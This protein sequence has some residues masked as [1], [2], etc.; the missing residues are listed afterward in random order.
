VACVHLPQQVCGFAV[1]GLVEST[2]LE[3]M[4]TRSLA[5]IRHHAKRIDIEVATNDA[6]AIANRISLIAIRE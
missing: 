4:V 1:L 5:A 2:F 3:T 6:V